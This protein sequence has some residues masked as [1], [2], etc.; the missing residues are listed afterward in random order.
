MRVGLTVGCVGLIVGAGL[1]RGVIGLTIGCV[2]QT[3][4]GGARHH[5]PES[6]SPARS[7]QTKHP[8]CLT[9]FNDASKEFLQK[10]ILT[11]RKSKR[12]TEVEEKVIK[13]CI[14]CVLKC[15]HYT[16]PARQKNDFP[17]LL[18]KFLRRLNHIFRFLQR[19]CK[20][21]LD[22]DYPKFCSG[23][24]KICSHNHHR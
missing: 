17:I 3:T 20:T 22:L 13:S 11:R 24:L 10:R 1:T 21:V 19:L 2:G 4:T 6:P 9:I 16:S 8:A 14:L 12:N 15:A 18:Y 23:F 5:L 7:W